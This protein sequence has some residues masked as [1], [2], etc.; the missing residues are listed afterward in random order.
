MKAKKTI[1]VD[2][3]KNNKT[4]E[5]ILIT[6]ALPYANGSIHIGH[7]LEYI[8]TDIFARALKLNSKDAIYICA[9][10]THGTP[11]QVNAMK[12]GIKPEE[13]IARFYE[14]H[15]KDFSEFHISFDNYYTTHSTENKVLVEFFFKKALDKGFVYKKQLKQLYCEHCKIFL[16][17]R[18]VKGKCPKCGAEDQYGDVCEKCGAVYKPTE[19][20]EPYCAICKNKPILKETEHFFFKLSAFSDK[21]KHWLLSNKE[22]QKEIVNSIMNWI[23]TGLE[24]WCISRDEPY[25]GFEIPNNP[26]K[27]FYVWLDAPIGYIASTWNYCKKRNIDYRDYWQ[28]EN[29][30]IIHVIGKDI[31]YFHFLFWPALLMTADFNLPFKEI[32]HG[33]VNINNEKMS[34][35][36]GT[37]IT[38]R[39]F[40]N[41]GINPE[42]LRFYFA[43]NTSNKL[44]DVNFDFSD[45]TEKINSELVAKIANFS[46]RILSFI[47][48]NFDS[49]IGSFNEN[50]YKELIE[51]FNE[52]KR[53]IIRNYED[54][55]FREAV[56]ELI[57]ISDLGNKFFQEKEPWN[58]IKSEKQKTLEIISFSA[59]LVKNLA[60]LIKPI[61]PEYSSKILEQMNLSKELSFKD[62]DFKLRN[63][64]VKKAEI[65]LKKIERTQLD[66]MI[67]N[68]AENKTE[69]KNSMRDFSKL[70]LRVAVVE[71]VQKHPNADKLYVLKINLGDHKR[72]LVAG[73]RAHYKEEELLGKHLIIVANLKQ[74]VIRGFKSEGMLLAVDD[75]NKVVVLE[76]K[77]TSPGEMVFIEGINRNPAREISIEEFLQIGLT[78]KNKKVV[79]DGKPLKTRDE[80]L[81]IDICDNAKI[82]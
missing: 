12:L 70:D 67:G 14:E 32:V 10:D 69:E 79:Y 62:I 22:L 39:Q 34:K 26:K 63:H 9:D 13:L 71:D 59:N 15:L 21:L 43:A 31:I 28:N 76:A 42:Y 16:P 36:R 77:K 52:S 61:L 5:R 75:G 8:T 7:L 54:F 57:M 74:A 72:Q 51:E 1:K 3:G 50:E 68:I 18:F 29:S 47:N 48:N 82:K 64:A 78:T 35:S 49:K 40:L 65:L 38:A 46:Y 81:T 60:I 45:F 30:K 37:F 53:K 2:F 6:A 73:L 66:S 56:K 23:D 25:F 11:I 4:K 41:T 24:D 19:L 44:S 58:S 20:I 33:Y 27:Y 17:D 80:E 55:N